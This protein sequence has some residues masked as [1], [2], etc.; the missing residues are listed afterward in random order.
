MLP[1]KNKIYAKTADALY[2]KLFDRYH[3]S[4]Q[5][6]SFKSIFESA[7]LEKHKTE[8][9]NVG[10]ISR[11]EYNYNRFITDEFGNRDITKISKFDIKAYTQEMV[12]RL[13]PKNKA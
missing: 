13:K 4:I 12:R 11:Y 5:D 1:G 2:D 10:T 3:L 8:N 9:V 6:S 7:L